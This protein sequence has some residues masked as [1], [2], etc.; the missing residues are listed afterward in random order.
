MK[1]QES[2]QETHPED[3]QITT[4]EKTEELT[5]SRKSLLPNPKRRR[6]TL[7]SQRS[8]LFQQSHDAVSERQQTTIKY[9]AEYTHYQPS[10]THYDAQQASSTRSTTTTTMNNPP[11]PSYVS[12]SYEQNSTNQT[13]SVNV[14]E[15]NQYD[16]E[17]QRYTSRNAISYQPAQQITLISDRICLLS[18]INNTL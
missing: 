4:A 13:N 5:E 11:S 2:Q 15:V 1:Q 10:T 9:S 12:P 3:I 6:I 17:V 16:L 14:A 18:T 7:L 8:N